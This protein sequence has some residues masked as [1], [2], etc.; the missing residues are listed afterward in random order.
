[1]FGTTRYQKQTFIIFPLILIIPI[2]SIGQDKL[3]LEQAW[4]IALMNNYTIQQQEN[5]I[6][7]AREEIAIQKTDF[8]PSLSASGLLT[9]ANFSKFPMKLPNESGKVGIDLVSL[10]I[11]QSIFSG[12]KTK[13]LVESAR[14]KLIA[15]EINKLMI[16]NTV[17]VEVGNLYYE[18]QYN[19]LQ[20]K[21]LEASINRVNNQKKNVYNLYLSEQATSFDTLEISNKKLQIENQL[22]ILKDTEI[23]LW[24]NFR[25]ILNEDELPPLNP[26][27]PASISQSKYNQTEQI[28]QAIQRRPELKNLSALK[29]AQLIYSDAL[30]AGYYP[31]LSASFSFNMLKGTGDIFIDEWT[32]FYSVMMN[33]QWELW[34]WNRNSKQV[35]QARIDIQNLELQELQLIQ[36]IKHQV[37]VASQNL[38]SS[39]KNIILQQKLVNQ[40][41]ERYQITEKRYNQGLATFRDLDSSELAYT[42]AE[43]ELH[44]YFI[45]WYKNKLQLD[46][47]TGL[48]SQ[49]IKEVSND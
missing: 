7:K 34:N 23:V 20:Q 49:N 37:T 44:K 2:L 3:T 21:V 30:K 32:N 28:N 41:K 42:E 12:M 17:L 18:I 4:D 16:Q 46:F 29:K 8:Y 26:L 27:S 24:S 11:N 38:Q 10:S 48:I 40:E 5:L 13:N 15:R 22:A 6:E 1:M 9:R 25:Y 43:L 19:H 47:A 39:Q 33:F 35:Q 31:Q 14:E 36:D 45:T